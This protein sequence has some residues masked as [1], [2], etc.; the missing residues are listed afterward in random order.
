MISQQSFNTLSISMLCKI[1]QICPIKCA[2]S[3]FNIRNQQND[4]K[5]K[6]KQ[7]NENKAN[8]VFALLKMQK[9]NN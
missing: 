1:T 9:L 8:T 4:K 5:Y 3:P 2:L 7:F 6:T